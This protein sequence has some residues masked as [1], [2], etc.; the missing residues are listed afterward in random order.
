M[1]DANYTS[2][3]AQRETSWGVPPSP[4]ALRKLRFTS[5]S[6]IHAKDVIASEEIRD[7][8]QIS[9]LAEVGSSASGTLE[10]ELSYLAWQEW[11]EAALFSSIVEINAAA[12]TVTAD[13]DDQTI[14][15]SAGTPF[16]NVI[17]GCF[18]RV[19]GFTNAGN[20]G[21]KLVTLVEN[22]NK[23]TLVAGGIVADQVGATVTIKG[24]HLKN[25]IERH[26]YFMERGIQSFDGNRYYQQ[27]SGM[28]VDQLEL[29]IESKQIVTGSMTFIGKYG[30]APD[31]SIQDST[32]SAASG[33]LTFTGQPTAAQTVTIGAR[34]YTFRATV[35]S[36]NDV[37]IGAN[38]Q[39]SLENLVAAI[40]GAAGAGVKYGT[41]T[42]T[43]EL[44]S[45]ELTASDDVTVTTREL[46][47]STAAT[48]TT[49][50]GATWGAAT[51]TGGVD[52]TPYEDQYAG[53]VLNGTSN[54]GSMRKDNLALEEKFK[55]LT[56]TI[57]NNLR[58]KDAIGEKGNWDVGVGSLEVTGN[59]SAYFRSNG[60]V[61]DFIYHE[62]TGISMVLTDG[63]GKSIGINLP[64]INFSTGGPQTE[65]KDTDLM[66]G[67]DFQ[68][69]LSDPLGGTIFVSFLD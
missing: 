6:L 63:N 65:G 68:A 44:V 8:R 10:F 29:N 45:A 35:P 39:E 31:G 38:A 46:G 4:P 48:T 3:A 49:V 53:P 69:I 52:V 18:V 66:Q 58:G 17:P 34:V 42:V 36:A 47:V 64:R 7:D 16:A 51:L 27:Y 57:A 50:T 28:M 11:L 55:T 21:V 13:A 67:M 24:K 62:Y 12:I 61:R 2:L 25:G 14:L 23:L 22:G 41:G 30:E 59:F 5:E 40:N 26:S 43:N 1:S 56:I 32:G 37:L 20:N 54:V 15:A 33:V 60:M 19:S 9:D